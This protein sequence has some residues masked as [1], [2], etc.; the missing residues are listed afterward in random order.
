VTNPHR[1][2]VEERE[3]GTYAIK[4]EGKERAARVL[5][6]ESKADKMAHH[7]AGQGDG[8]V[9]YKGADGRFEKCTCSHC[10]ENR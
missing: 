2:F 1:Y 5:T 3:N 4:G 10:R 8:V 9:E 6:S 7:F